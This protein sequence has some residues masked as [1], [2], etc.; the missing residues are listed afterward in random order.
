MVGAGVGSRFED[1]AVGDGVATVGSVDDV[2]VVASTD[3]GAVSVCAVGLS[4]DEW[5]VGGAVGD[6]SVGE[7]M[8]AVGPGDGA[9]FPEGLPIDVVTVGA[10][11]GA[12]LPDGLPI[13]GRMEGL[14]SVGATK[15]GPDEGLKLVESTV[16]VG[17]GDSAGTG[18]ARADGA[19]DV[20]GKKRSKGPLPGKGTNADSQ[21]VMRP[22]GRFVQS[23]VNISD[24]Q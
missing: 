24:P 12:G 11:V 20:N 23:A 3:G 6:C 1:V 18:V 9:G 13:E 21:V 7:A 5:V 16:V 8:M 15:L 4:I 17:G 2:P 19:S 22:F 10:E 14:S